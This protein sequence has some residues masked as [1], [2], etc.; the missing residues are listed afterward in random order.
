MGFLLTKPV[1]VNTGLQKCATCDTQIW[2]CYT[3]KTPVPI[4]IKFDVGDYIVDVTSE[5]KIQNDH[6]IGGICAYG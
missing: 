6:P 2:G 3:S 1:A 4:D 5:S